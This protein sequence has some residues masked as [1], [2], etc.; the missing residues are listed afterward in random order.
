MERLGIATLDMQSQLAHRAVPCNVHDPG[1]GVGKWVLL[2]TI[3]VPKNSK[4]AA[5]IL[6]LLD[7]S[8]CARPAILDYSPV[9]LAVLTALCAIDRR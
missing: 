8:R 5:G 9:A 4:R 1:F 2:F 6:P 3:S 7:N